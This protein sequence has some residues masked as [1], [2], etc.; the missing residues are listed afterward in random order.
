[1]NVTKNKIKQLQTG[2]KIHDGRGLYFFK[3][4][5]K[6]RWSFRYQRDGQCHEMGCGIYPEVTIAMSR[7]QHESYKKS[8]SF[9]F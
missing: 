8:K 1:M 3:K 7:E 5:D 2:K 9:I 4:G 6:G